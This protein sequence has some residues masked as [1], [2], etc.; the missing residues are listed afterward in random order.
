M[1]TRKI[2]AALS[3]ILKMATLLLLLLNCSKVDAQVKI[4][5]KEKKADDKIIDRY[6]RQA[7]REFV[8]DQID[9]ADRSNQE[10]IDSLLKERSITHFTEGHVTYSPDKKFK[11]FVFDGES[12]GGICTCFHDAFLYVAGSTIK[13]KLSD[14]TLPIDTIFKLNDG[15]YLVLEKDQTCGGNVRYDY[16]KAVLLSFKNNRVIYHRFNY[17]DPRYGANNNNNAKELSLEQLVDDSDD[18]LLKFDPLT[19]SL[20]YKYSANLERCCNGTGAFSYIGY[21]KYEKGRFVH[22]KETKVKLKD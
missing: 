16:K 14:E 13:Q 12:C 19:N 11:I 3:G 20:S 8:L 2:K 22:K 6:I 5:A 9:T 7:N 18:M 15:K 17:S 10:L 1:G 21:F 4:S